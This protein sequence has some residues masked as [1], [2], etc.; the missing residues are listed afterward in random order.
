MEDDLIANLQRALGP[1]EDV[2]VAYVFGSAARGQL[3]PASDLDVAVL[4]AVPP[5]APGSTGAGRPTL[6]SLRS[7]LQAD[8]QE[9][10]H[11]TVDLVVLNHA[12][13][14]LTHR[15]LRDGVL[16]IERDRS[17]RIRFE[18]EARNQYFDVLPFLNRYRAAAL[19]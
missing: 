19:R 5:V 10:A 14:D 17:A 6:S 2:I 16:L 15:V 4:M 11:R 3:R 9:A 8:L 13:P 12:S 7:G 18:V 1:H